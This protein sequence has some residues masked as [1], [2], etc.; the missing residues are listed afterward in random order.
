MPYC[1]GG[2][3]IL[4][5]LQRL[6]REDHSNSRVLP[7]WLNHVSCKEIK[8]ECPIDITEIIR[9]HH[10][11]VQHFVTKRSM[12]HVALRIWA[13]IQKGKPKEVLLDVDI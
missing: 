1:L 13:V 4:T 8:H 12:G 5:A 11:A 2:A 7:D 6:Y 3:H 10:N 9:G